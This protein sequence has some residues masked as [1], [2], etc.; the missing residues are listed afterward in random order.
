MTN[1]RTSSVCAELHIFSYYDDDDV[2]WQAVFNLTLSQ[3]GSVVATIVNMWGYSRWF[4]LLRSALAEPTP[5][6][7]LASVGSPGRRR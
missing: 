4:S 3:R 5:V 2:N 7:V 6:F 1:G